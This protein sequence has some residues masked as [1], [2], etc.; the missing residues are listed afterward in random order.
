MSIVEPY[1][2]PYPYPEDR[3]EDFLNPPSFTFTT[4]GL[5]AE[6]PIIQTEETDDNFIIFVGVPGFKRESFKIFTEGDVLTVEGNGRNLSLPN[7]LSHE[8]T[9]T[10]T[11]T[12]LPKRQVV[13]KF[14]NGLLQISVSKL[15][16]I[17]KNPVT[18]L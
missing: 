3:Q 12:D 9:K 17:H 13:A 1:P 16:E 14:N 5:T 2:Y 18:I 7:L 6:V 8:F 10:F 4:A 11:Y 15:Q